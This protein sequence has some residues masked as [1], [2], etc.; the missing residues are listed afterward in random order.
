MYAFFIERINI[1]SN[2]LNGYSI[3]IPKIFKLE[4]NLWFVP[5]S[6]VSKKNQKLIIIFE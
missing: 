3:I 1:L 5:L 4:K 2:L 6:L